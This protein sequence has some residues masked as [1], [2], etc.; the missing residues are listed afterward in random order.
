MTLEQLV[1]TLD[2]CQQLKVAGFPQDTA[3]VWVPAEEFDEYEVGENRE[4]VLMERTETLDED[5]EPMYEFCATPTAG[6]LE[7]WLM[8]RSKCASLVMSPGFM[9]YWQS[10]RRKPHRVAVVTRV[11]A[12][13]ALILEVAG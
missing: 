9:G 6:E 2:L 12:L 11:S 4:P 1:P 13:V 7:E 3:M 8:T 5:G 10:A